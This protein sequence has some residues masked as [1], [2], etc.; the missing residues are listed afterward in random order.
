M[1]AGGATE[2][3]KSVAASPAIRLVDSFVSMATIFWFEDP[4][5]SPAASS[6]YLCARGGKAARG[7]SAGGQHDLAFY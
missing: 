1:L 3:G 5:L 2:A 4:A 6:S 7:R